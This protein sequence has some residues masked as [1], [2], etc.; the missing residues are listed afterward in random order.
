MG[1]DLAEK[2]PDPGTTGE[3]MEKLVDRNPSSMFL[4]A[5]EDAEILD[6]VNNCK[7]K[8]STDFQ[9]MDM[10]LVK[11]VIPAI[12]KPLT[13]IFNLSF[14]TGIFPDG[15]KTAKVIA[16]YKAGSKHNFTNY[17]P[18]SLLPQFSKILEKLF[19][20][21]LEAFLEKHQ[22]LSDSQYGFRSNKS[23]S[24]AIIESIEEITMAIDKKQQAIGVFIDLKK[25]FDTINHDILI[26]KLEKYR[27]RG[28]V[29]DWN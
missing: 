16:L 6:I 4:K 21:R 5:V 22:L 12:V 29:L 13:H 25:A 15:M 18:V 20:S 17:R 28:V 3:M 9:D 11:L 27:V 2:I 19:N 1:P 24:S 7:N 14:Q 10:A 8:R 23:T 26:C